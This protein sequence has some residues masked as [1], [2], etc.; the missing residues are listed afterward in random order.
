MERWREAW[1]GKGAI[2]NGAISWGGGWGEQPRID[3]TIHVDIKMEMAVY[4]RQL[5]TVTVDETD[6]VPPT[7]GVA[8]VHILL[9][10]IRYTQSR[11]IETRGS[12]NGKSWTDFHSWNTD[13]EVASEASTL[14]R[15][16]GSL[17][18]ADYIRKQVENRRS[19]V[20][21]QEYN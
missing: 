7:K 20:S 8:Y 9:C 5:R 4:I 11:Q 1:G 21:T 3:L 17:R 2:K 19:K 15:Y 10:S 12:T 13:G 14:R 6:Q 16:L 18:T